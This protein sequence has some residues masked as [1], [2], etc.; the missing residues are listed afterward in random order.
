M[1][2]NYDNYEHDAGCIQLLVFYFF[3][4]PSFV[5]SR[6]LLT[7]LLQFVTHRLICTFY[8]AECQ[9]GTVVS[10]NLIYLVSNDSNRFNHLMI[11][12]WYDVTR[13]I[14]MEDLQQVTCWDICL[15]GPRRCSDPWCWKSSKSKGGILHSRLSTG[16]GDKQKQHMIAKQLSINTLDEFAVFFM[17]VTFFAL[18]PLLSL[19]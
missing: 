16:L 7:F 10:F 11:L 6:C 5:S 18:L 19:F 2:M 4:N 13:P 15:V 12:V 14:F 3:K 8:H 9:R 17:F 1:T